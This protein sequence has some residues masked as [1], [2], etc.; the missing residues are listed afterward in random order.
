MQNIEIKYHLNSCRYI[1]QKLNDHPEI[2]FA[3]QIYQRD[4]YFN[5]S[6]GRLKIRFQEGKPTQLIHYVRPDS[7]TPRIS[8]YTIEELPNPL[9]KVAEFQ[10]AYGILDQVEKWRELYFFRN[11]RIHLD[12]VTHL[13]WFIEFESVIDENTSRREAQENLE[14]ILEYLSACL[15]RPVTV[16]YI[17]LMLEKK[18]DNA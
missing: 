11:V 9:A 2:R 12:N 17:N 14:D 5:V 8:N 4:V 13:G 1:K 3:E 7:D 16:S 18:Q 15:T 10:K 6:D